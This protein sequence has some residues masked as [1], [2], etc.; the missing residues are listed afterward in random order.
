VC[1]T[2]VELRTLTLA[3]FSVHVPSRALVG[4][5]PRAWQESS[6]GGSFAVTALAL[7]P[8]VDRMASSRR[9]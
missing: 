9:N 5:I 3:P 2:S 6:L 1:R 7:W 4:V 8:R